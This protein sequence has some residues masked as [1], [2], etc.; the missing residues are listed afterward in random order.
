MGGEK[1]LSWSHFSIERAQ[2]RYPDGIERS[3][4]RVSHPGAVVIVPIG[5]N[6]EYIIERQYRAAV[7]RWLLE[8]PAGTMESQEDPLACAQRELAEEVGLAAHQWEYLGEMFPAPGF[9]DE[10][11]HLYI[12]RKLYEVPIHPDEDEFIDTLT[13]T[14]MDIEQQIMTGQLCDSKSVAAYYRAQLAQKATC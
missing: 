12:A 9:S 11:Q 13:L 5:E 3:V 1:L 2:Q 7:N 14:G 4:T 6:G 8:F 10:Q